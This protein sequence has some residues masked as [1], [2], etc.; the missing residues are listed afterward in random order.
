VSPLVR[1]LTIALLVPPSEP[2]FAD[3][4]RQYGLTGAT[5][6]GEAARKD[7][8]FETTGS[9]AVIFD[10]DNDGR[11]DVLLV[12]GTRRGAP[13]H[14]RPLLFRNRGEGRFEDVA[15]KVWPEGAGWGQGACAADFDGD[16]RIDVFIAHYGADRL[17]RN[18]ADGFLDV[19][20]RAGLPVGSHRWGAAC[21]FLDFDRD[22]R[23]DVFVSNYAGLDAQ[24]PPKPGSMTDCFWKGTPVACGPK[25]LPAAFHVLYHQRADGTF[26][27]V[28]EKAGIRKPGARYGLGVVS[29][30][31]NNDGWPDI[32]V[33]CDQ[34]PSLLYENRRNG[35]FVERALEAGVAFNNDGRTQAG[36]GVA[37]AD[38]DGDG[39]LDIVK[40]NFS[41][42]LPN[43][44]RNE[45]G[46]F[47]TDIAEAAGLGANLLLG[48]GVAF[49]DVDDDGWRD[50]LMVNGHVYPEVEK[51]GMGDRYRQKVLLYRNLGNRRF[52]ETQAIDGM[53]A[54]RG[55]A[56]GDLDGDGRPEAVVTN[57]DAPPLV[58]KNLRP[59]G[60]YLNLE[61]R[62]RG[63]STGARVTLR[64]GGKTQI[65]EVMNGSSYFSQHEAA[66]HFGV[67]AARSVDAV[68]VRWPDGKI[69]EWKQ[70][71]VNTRCTLSQG[72][73]EPRC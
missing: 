38:F 67:G 44:Y 51:A 12:N 29:A 14:P 59:G 57:M 70:L 46:K 23:L 39:F 73:A 48:W 34:T 72:Q 35:T 27:D 50:L 64:A 60:N 21:T 62:A 19:S 37:V 71:P 63:A 66:L 33:A 3:V 69:E 10:F 36:M 22:G 4:A 17:Y 28:S 16:S 6:A 11:N 26:E 55:L 40:T 31:F 24:N 65:D 8:L 25:G 61:L 56:I 54:S 30:D 2:Q 42:E 68:T 52:A 13:E 32:Y 18:T 41:G 20:A 15:A 49:L 1:L 43:L 45:N 58:L 5:V 9:G 7:F 53:W 47:F